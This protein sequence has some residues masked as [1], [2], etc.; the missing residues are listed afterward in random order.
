[1][2]RTENWFAISC[3][4]SGVTE[5]NSVEYMNYNQ[6]YQDIIT[7]D[8]YVKVIGS[9]TGH[10]DNIFHWACIQRHCVKVVYRTASR[11]PFTFLGSG[12][13]IQGFSRYQDTIGPRTPLENRS[14]YI[15]HIP[16]CNVKHVDIPNIHDVSTFGR[17][18]KDVMHFFNVSLHEASTYGFYYAYP[19]IR[20]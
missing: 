15:I 11:K 6:I 9:P 18:K 3:I 1:M 4:T 20:D 19:K 10:R 5:V 16:K 2:Q 14:W 12:N 7:G 8:Y 13:I 17:Y